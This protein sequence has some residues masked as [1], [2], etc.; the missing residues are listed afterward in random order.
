M[1]L[2]AAPHL[3]RSRALLT[4]TPCPPCHRHPHRY[5]ALDTALRRPEHLPF[6]LE[7]VAFHHSAAIQAQAVTLA[8]QLCDRMPDLMLVLL[9]Q[10]RGTHTL[11]LLRNGFASALQAG[12][13]AQQMAAQGVDGE[14]G[15]CIGLLL[16]LRI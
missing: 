13:Q 2:H 14:E 8:Q 4:L 10:P 15:G 12:L 1:L 9:Q 3:T 5:Q 11:A 7:Y 16:L 6:L